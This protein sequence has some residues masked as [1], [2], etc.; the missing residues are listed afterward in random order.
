[1]AKRSGGGGGG[2]NPR[3]ATGSS[4]TPAGVAAALDAMRKE[5]AQG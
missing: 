4:S 5:L 1:L 3:M 2:G